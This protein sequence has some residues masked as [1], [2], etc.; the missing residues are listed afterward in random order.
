M[1]TVLGICL[2]QEKQN[3]LKHRE[4]I[5]S[6]FVDDRLQAELLDPSP[7]SPTSTSRR[8]GSFS[9]VASTTATGGPRILGLGLVW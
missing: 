2:S 3:N 6:T 8:G 7:G 4:W 9:S 1:N 5:W